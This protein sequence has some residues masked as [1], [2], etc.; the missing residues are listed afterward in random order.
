MEK[1]SGKKVRKTRLL[2]EI[3][4]AVLPIFIFVSGLVAYVLYRT[5]IDNFVAS[6]RDML[7]AQLANTVADVGYLDNRLLYDFWEENPEITRQRLSDKEE[8]AIYEYMDKTNYNGAWTEAWLSSIEDETVKEYIARDAYHLM[9]QWTSY[10]YEQREYDTLFVFDASEE[11]RGFVFLDVDA[12]G[13]F[14]KDLGDY[15][16]LNIKDHPVLAEAMKTNSGKIIYEKSTNFPAEGSYYIVY[17]PLVFNGKIRAFLAVGV[18]YSDIHEKVM[19]QYS[20]VTLISIMG[21]GLLFAVLFLLILFRS[22]EPVRKIQ[23]AVRAYIYTK[24]SSVIIDKMSSIKMNN[25]IGQLSDD[26][27]DLAKEIDKYTADIVAM[28]SER[29]RVATELD[30]AKNIQEGQLPSKFP[31]FPDRNEFD[32]YASMTAAKEVG[33]DFYDFFF[34][35]DDHLALVMADVSG[36]GVPASLFMMMSKMLIHNYTMIGLSPHEVLE[37]TN[38][39]LFENNPEKMFVTVWLGILEISTGKIVA[40]NAGHEYPVIKQPDGDFELFKDKHGFVLGGFRDKKYKEYEFT[41]QRGGTLFVYTDGVPEATN[42]HG[43]MYG[44]ER[45]VNDINKYKDCTPKEILQSIH[46]DVD[47]FVGD[48]DQF[49]DLTMMAIK[50]H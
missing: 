10:D 19:N 42:S 8:D 31:A 29:Q 1:G 24:N 2:I 17:K 32:I 50:L 34:V 33:G 20:M 26:I 22:I 39:S 4:T 48:A 40:S 41:L 7:S 45:L 11:H 47:S 15:L 43:E 18:D 23:S 49:D 9:R 37:R 3:A 38:N 16:D 27:V 35:D 6:T 36:K 28:T 30:M 13:N 21:I 14:R 44:T 25:E 5:S 12:E 46:S